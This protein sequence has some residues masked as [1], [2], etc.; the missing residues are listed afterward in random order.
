MAATPN[1]DIS[2]GIFVTEKFTKE[3]KPSRSIY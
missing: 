2:K 3:K 1:T